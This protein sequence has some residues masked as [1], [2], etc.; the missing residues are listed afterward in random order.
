MGK[1]EREKDLSTVRSISHS[2]GFENM[3]SSN[4]PERVAGEYFKTFAVQITFWKFLVTIG[5]G[6][7][8]RTALDFS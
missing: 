1:T 7:I 3:F 2:L 5:K 8:R 6:I 4:A